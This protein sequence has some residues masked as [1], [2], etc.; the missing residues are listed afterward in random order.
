MHISGLHNYINERNGHN[1]ITMDNKKL[2]K[3]QPNEIY[4][5]P[6]VWGFHVGPIFKR[7]KAN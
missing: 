3:R 5:N 7:E 4:K 2:I 1:I 6:H